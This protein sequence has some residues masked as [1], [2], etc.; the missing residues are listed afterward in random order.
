MSFKS[1][2]RDIL[3][4]N[5]F[6]NAI[7]IINVL[8]GSTNSVLHLLA[9]ARA[10]DIDLNIDDFQKVADRTPYLADLRLVFLIP[11]WTSLQLIHAPQSLWK[12]RYGRSPQSGWYSRFGQIFAQ[13]HRLDRRYT[14]H[15]YR[16]DIGREL[17]RCSRP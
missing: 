14:A 6:L 13:E 2:Y 3:T 5:S 9:M 12:V 15:G 7:A 1:C 17:R 8:G 16:E 10:A 4:R 11:S